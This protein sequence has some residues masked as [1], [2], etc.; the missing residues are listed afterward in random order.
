MGVILI[1]E[2]ICDFCGKRIADPS[3]GFRGQLDLRK[4]H[5]KGTGRRVNLVLHPACLSK[6]TRAATKA[7]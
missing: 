3:A 2:L 1:E 5:A 6:L 7:R 4:P